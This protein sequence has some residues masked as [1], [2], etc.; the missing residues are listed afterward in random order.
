MIRH[1][2]RAIIVLAASPL[3]ACTGAGPS[4]SPRTLTT[5][6]T[7]NAGVPEIPSGAKTLDFWIP[8]PSDGTL[9]TIRDLKV[10]A[11]GEYKINRESKY[12]N[13]MVYLRVANPAGPVNVTVQFT[14]DR[15][16]ALV[17]GSDSG[18]LI[19]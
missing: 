14:V 9:Q 10:D 17:L 12:G 5:Q 7:Y 15:K 19:R 3:C 1:L 13:R 16:E 18:S 8:I 4:P 2:S 11:P 6:F